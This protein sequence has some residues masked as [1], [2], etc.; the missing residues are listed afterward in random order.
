MT[1]NF[2]LKSVNERKMACILLCVIKSKNEKLE[3]RKS[4]LLFCPSSEP[5]CEKEEFK[6]TNVRV[7][8]ERMNGFNVKR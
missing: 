2:I 3:L 6:T 7:W 4:L 8:T 1:L 5:G